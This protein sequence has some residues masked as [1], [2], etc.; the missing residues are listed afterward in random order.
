[1][2]LHVS[3][4]GESSVAVAS[5][6]GDMV[7]DKVASRIFA[8]DHTLWGPD[9]QAEASIRLGWVDAASESLELVPEVLELRKTLRSTG[10]NRVVLCGMGGS[11]LAPEVIAAS[12]GVDLVVLDATHPSQVRSAVTKNLESTVVVVSSK[13]G[14]TVET[15]SQKRIF[16]QAF[17]QAGIDKTSRIIVVTDP[18]SPMHKQAVLDGYR[19]F[20]ANPNVGGRYS[21]LT[22]FGVV[23]SV[24]AGVDMGPI[25]LEAIST[26]IELSRD[27]ES[28]P[29]LVLGAAIARTASSQG[30]RDKLGIVSTGDDLLGLGNWMEQLI[31]ESTGKMGRG[32]LPIVLDAYSPEAL[33]PSDDIVTIGL[34]SD[35]SIGKYDIN[36]SGGLG[37]QFL[38]WEVATAVASMLLEVNPFD[39]PDVESAKV[40]SRRF[41]DSKSQ[42]EE[43]FFVDGAISVSVK[44]IPLS[45]Q[46]T[47]S[48]ALH[49]LLQ[50]ADARSYFAIHGYLDRNRDESF[51]RL[52]ELI[53]KVS[54]RPTTFGWGPRFLHSTG[55]YHKGGPA[56]GLFLQLIGED[57]E[58]LMVPGRNFGF[59]ELMN[60]QAAGDANVLSEIGRPV[61]TL[62]FKDQ[63]KA[64]LI[65]LE[66]LEA[67]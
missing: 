37:S 38:L 15:D 4:R 61:V 31:A 55:Q 19:V 41:L 7:R 20:L 46:P 44:N 43:P 66:I 63:K 30:L 25:L 65:I 64:L 49:A 29:A 58:E 51:Q 35:T 26:A 39:Q 52:R 24:L 40:A 60:S 50:A 22:A 53:A 27:Y 33:T 32:L 48:E 16:E 6:I 18:D 10:L 12:S 34:D 1:M 59:Q 54:G 36:V 17:E 13:S 62:R 67:L 56:Q 11:S 57:E 23:P 47:L 5:V 3:T 8:K 42:N 28:N 45:N 14:S 2:T 21:A 9:A